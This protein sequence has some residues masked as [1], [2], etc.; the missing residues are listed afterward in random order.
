[1]NEVL[2]C[3]VDDPEDVDGPEEGFPRTQDIEGEEDE[4][5]IP[6]FEAG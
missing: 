1:M 4:E 5:I 2:D 6:T 3:Q